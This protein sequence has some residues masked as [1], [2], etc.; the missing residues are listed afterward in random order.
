MHKAC[1]EKND[2]W[3]AKAAFKA[4]ILIL[5][6]IITFIGGW[7]S[8][9]GASTHAGAYTCIFLCTW[10]LHIDVMAVQLKARDQHVI[11]ICQI[12]AELCMSS[13]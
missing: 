3:A 6:V 12:H 13:I 11:G 7:T 9:L 8:V 4:T 1:I 2:Y 10:E 5:T